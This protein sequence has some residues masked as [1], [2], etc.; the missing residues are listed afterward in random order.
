M[1][2]SW[3]PHFGVPIFWN[4]L[5]L[6]KRSS[7]CLRG[8]AVFCCSLCIAWRRQGPRA[9]GTRALRWTC[10]ACADDR[11]CCAN[12]ASSSTAA[13]GTTQESGSE[14]GAGGAMVSEKKKTYIFPVPLILGLCPL[15][16]KNNCLSGLWRRWHQKKCPTDREKSF[17]AL[18]TI[19]LKS[20][21]EKNRNRFFV[22][23]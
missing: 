11:G 20:G 22:E 8:S 10:E 4:S 17:W 15:R 5:T 7:G 16:R 19:T 12:R 23:I 6:R 2:S 9:G 13:D 18:Q 3:V 1:K 14:A 21:C